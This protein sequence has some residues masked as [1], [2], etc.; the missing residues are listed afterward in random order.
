MSEW[1]M[2]SL[3]GSQEILLNKNMFCEVVLIATNKQTNSRARWTKHREEKQDTKKKKETRPIK[4][5]C[6]RPMEMLSSSAIII[7]HY[8]CCHTEI[9]FFSCNFTWI[10]YSFFLSL[11]LARNVCHFNETTELLWCIF[12][13]LTKCL[14]ARLCFFSFFFLFLTGRSNRVVLWLE[15]ELMST[16]ARARKLNGRTDSGFFRYMLFNLS[17]LSFAYMS[18]LF[19]LWNSLSRL[20]SIHLCIE[21]V[22]AWWRIHF[23]LIYF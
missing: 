20:L 1:A 5:R 23:T 18:F 22:F 14:C 17:S 12:A 4:E 15:R 21:Y 2:K 9:L 6:V 16:F 13:S 8:D 10:T 19:F 3:W 7:F 11:S